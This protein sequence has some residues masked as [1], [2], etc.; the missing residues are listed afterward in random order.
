MIDQ[1]APSSLRR[2]QLGRIR[3]IDVARGVALVAMAIYHFTWDLEFF[4]YLEP[5]LTAAGGWKIFARCIASSFLFLVG[6]SLVLAHARGVRWRPFLVRLLQVAG[7]AAAISLVTWFAV[8]GGFIFF[9]ILH[10]IA[11]ASL[12]GVLLLRL[13]ATLLVALAAFVI[14]AP[15]FLRSPLFD[16]AGLWW[17]GLSSVNPHSNDYVPLFPWF[18]AVLLGMAA[19]KLAS[20]AGVL[21]CLRGRS[22]WRPMEPLEWAG[23]HSL[24]FYLVHQPVLMALVWTATQIAPPPAPD[25]RVGFTRA[26]QAQCLQV[27]DQPFCTS[28][29]GCVMENATTLP[30]GIAALDNSA[31]DPAL[32]RQVGDIVAMCS[33]EA[34]LEQL[35]GGIDE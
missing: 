19:A 8:P 2:P 15:S 26:C 16:A 22:L 17:V 30:G 27:R 28:Y 5:G 24:A 6:V 35:E 12:L 1:P 11:L 9:G 13:P 25:P 33:G 21:D 18:G 31:N 20:K 29:C 23:K 34:D 32:Q 14:A 3:A 7:A 4:G 10:Q